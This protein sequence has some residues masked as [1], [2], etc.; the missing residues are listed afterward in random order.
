MEPDNNINKTQELRL[1]HELQVHQVELEM[2]NEE[3]CRT[4]DELE[5]LLAKYTELFD[6]APVGYPTLGQDGTIIAA[7]LTVCSLFGINRSLILDRRMGIFV[8]RDDRKLFSDF[9]DKVFASTNREMC[10]IRL[11]DNWH[12]IIMA[13]VEALVSGSGDECRAAVIDVTE[14]K[15]VERELQQTVVSLQKAIADREKVEQQLL[16]SQKMES[17]GLLAGGVAHEFNNMLAAIIGFGD[18]IRGGLPKDRTDLLECIEQLLNGA[19]RAA[20]LTRSLLAFSRRQENKPRPLLID[21]LIANTVK[22]IR[23]VIGE[24][25]ELSFNLPS[26][27]LVVHADPGQMEQVLLNLATNARDAMP[28]GGRLRIDTNV[29][30]I[31]EGSE[32]LYDLP[33]P[34]GYAMISIT[35]NGRGIEKELLPRLFEPFYTTKELGKGTGLG[36]SIVYGIIK[37]HKGSLLVSSELGQGTTFTFYLPLYDGKLAE[38]EIAAK[39]PV[40]GGSETL[41]VVEDEEIVRV[42]LQKILGKAGYRII[43]AGDGEEALAKFKDHDD[44][45]MVISDVVMPKNISSEIIGEMRGLKP[46]LKLIFISGYTADVLSQKGLRKEG[47]ELITKPIKKDDLLRKIRESLDK[48]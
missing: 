41:L 45:S 34:G 29:V 6:F 28:G 4:R 7:N 21:T 18:E 17:I 8:A 23:K 5:T 12:K 35:D 32:M 13:R 10:E 40:A 3:L 33:V 14:Q 22:L 37:Q 11:R 2:Q 43:V 31:K 38:E 46:H 16:Q 24:D 30:E 9:L 44:I 39:Q 19:W 20:E 15:R 25:I 27:S 1:L 48:D 36:L 47:T 42:F 26:K